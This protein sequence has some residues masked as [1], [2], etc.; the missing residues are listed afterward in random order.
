M[1]CITAVIADPEGGSV[2]Q[3]VP[4]LPRADSQRAG[5]ARVP[6]AL[7]TVPTNEFAQGRTGGQ[8]QGEGTVDAH[9]H[10]QAHPHPYTLTTHT[11]TQR[12][13]GGNHLFCAVPSRETQTNAY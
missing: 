13:R 9:R 8:L 3:Q 11:H 10:M 4:E 12:K 1:A 7:Q 5:Q 2:Y 6:R